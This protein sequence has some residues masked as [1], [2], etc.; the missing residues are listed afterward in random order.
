MTCDLI[1]NKYFNKYFIITLYCP[2]YV[3]IIMKV[4]VKKHANSR[5][6]RHFNQNHIKI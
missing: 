1:I 3:E 4:N 5:M 6:R 2:S